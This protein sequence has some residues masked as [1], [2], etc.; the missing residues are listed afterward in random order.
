MRL[1]VCHFPEVPRALELVDHGVRDARECVCDEALAGEGF[2]VDVGEG[3]YVGGH[4]GAEV[5]IH[6]MS[7]FVV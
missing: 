5:N 6:F 7:L 3:G 4:G 1:R 2:D